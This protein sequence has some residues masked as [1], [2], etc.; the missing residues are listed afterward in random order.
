MGRTVCSWFQFV[1]FFFVFCFWRGEGEG[2]GEGELRMRWWAGLVW[3][4][5]AKS[6]SGYPFGYVC[7]F[8]D[9]GGWNGM[10]REGREEK[11]DVM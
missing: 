9:G 5:Q 3:S 10:G 4:G 7:D 2:E 11:W 1:S 8:T 6:L